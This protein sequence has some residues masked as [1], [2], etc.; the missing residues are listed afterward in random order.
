M[1][2]CA[3]TGIQAMLNEYLDP[4]VFGF[5][6]RAGGLALWFALEMHRHQG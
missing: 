6:D 5:D 4:V 2:G 1:D 3:S